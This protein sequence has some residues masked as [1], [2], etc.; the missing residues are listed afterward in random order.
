MNTQ[1]PKKSSHLKNTIVGVVALSALTGGLLLLEDYRSNKEAMKFSEHLSRYAVPVKANHNSLDSESNNTT[2]FK[3]TQ[4]DSLLTTD[5]SEQAAIAEQN[6]LSQRESSVLGESGLS[7]SELR[8]SRE[9]P[10]IQSLSKTNESQIDNNGLT[11]SE[12]NENDVADVY[13]AL[14]S[15]VIAPEYKLQ[16]VSVAEHIKS[17]ADTKRWQVVGNTDKSGSATYNLTLAKE[18]AKN[19]AD[20]LV[21]QGIAEDQLTLLTLGEYEAMKLENS[22][23]NYGLRKVS[24]MEYK[25]ETQQLAITVQKRNEKREKRR[26]A[27]IE[28]RKEEQKKQNENSSLL[29]KQQENPLMHEQKNTP[30]NMHVNDPDT[31]Q[32]NT[33]LLLDEINLG[34]E[35]QVHSDT[36]LSS[37][38]SEHSDVNKPK[39]NQSA[40]KMVNEKAIIESKE[41]FKINSNELNSGEQV[42]HK[43]EMDNQIIE[44]TQVSSII[45]IWAL[46]SA[47]DYSL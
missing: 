35:Q 1:L 44:S 47:S 7:S 21:N 9:V 34:F 12:D 41:R 31:V 18:R 13:F 5:V 23:Y 33:D 20:F 6:L 22:T 17:Q 37:Y 11:R 29:T 46:A 14:S 27:L 24:V 39:L 8:A 16:L 40:Q 10:S 42:N 38:K 2:F 45:N 32:V 4:D 26:I 19:V 15:S 43:Q 25:P 36:N 3:R 28:Q 30:I